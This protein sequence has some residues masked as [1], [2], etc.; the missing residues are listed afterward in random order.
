M[1]S[2]LGVDVKSTADLLD[3]CLIYSVMK[4]FSVNEVWRME[5]PELFLILFFS[6]IS[7]ITF[8]K[9]SQ[10]PKKNHFVSG[11]IVNIIA[12]RLC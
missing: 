12:G 7:Q 8:S 4:I 6:Q 11:V 1:W 2:K 3:I 5:H 9:R 10:L